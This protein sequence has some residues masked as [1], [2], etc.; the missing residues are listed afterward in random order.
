MA[1]KK[2]VKSAK[3]G[4]KQTSQKGSKDNESFLYWMISKISI[5][6]RF[7]GNW[8]FLVSILLFGL[9]FP[10]AMSFGVM[11]FIYRSFPK[12][13]KLF[14]RHLLV[15]GIS[16]ILISFLSLAAIGMEMSDIINMTFSS[17]VFTLLLGYPFVFAWLWFDWN[18]GLNA[19]RKQ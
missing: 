3:T 6:P 15:F 18:Y 11:Y 10:P 13:P 16:L 19:N 12:E 14:D 9:L 1:R 7:E 4:K 2:T 5:H 17:T 8:I